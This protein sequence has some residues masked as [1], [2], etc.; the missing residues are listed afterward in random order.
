MSLLFPESWQLLFQ[1]LLSTRAGSEVSAPSIRVA[2]V[3][4]DLSRGLLLFCQL[5]MLEFE[6]SQ[7]LAP[8]AGEW[9]E[10]RSKLAKAGNLGFSPS[11]CV[12]SPALCFLAGWDFERADT[13]TGWRSTRG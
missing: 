6:Q 9:A 5:S 3:S 8:S 2:M 1:K 12:H 10:D 7:P 4:R 11:W 13:L